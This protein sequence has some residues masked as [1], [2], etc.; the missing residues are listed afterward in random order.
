MLAHELMKGYIRRHQSPHCV[1]QMDIQKAYDTVEWLV[2]NFP[3]QFVDW[4][5]TCVCSI[6]YRFAI[7]GQTTKSGKDEITK[8]APISWDK[9]YSPKGAGGLN[10]GDLKTWNQETVGSYYGIFR[11]KMISYG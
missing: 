9:I 2:L 7:R 11:P 6:S 10:N 5:M 3:E 8:K 1:I 4:T